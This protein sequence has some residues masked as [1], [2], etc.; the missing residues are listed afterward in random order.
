V[1]GEGAV[2]AEDVPRLLYSEMFFSES[3]RLYPP[4]WMFVRVAVEDDILP[5]G[6][7]IPA[8]SKI[9]FCQY[10]AH[11]NEAFFPDPERFDPERFLAGTGNAW[12]R[13]AYFPFGGGRRVCVAESLA[14]L[15]GVLLL[16][17]V[18]RRFD[19][20]LCPGQNV[21][22]VGAIT[23]RPRDPIRVAVRPAENR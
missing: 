2:A 7:R 9:F 23:L 4:V 1:V 6:V 11:R 5:S 15:E 3:L 17:S 14:R 8:G 22:P 20:E 19:L 13:F 21:E 10:T 16:A 12:P 18:A